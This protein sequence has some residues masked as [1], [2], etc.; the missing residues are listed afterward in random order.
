MQHQV[1]AT[2]AAAA[3][4]ATTTCKREHVKIEVYHALQ[5][6]TFCKYPQLLLRIITASRQL[7][8]HIY[9]GCTTLFV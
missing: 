7:S 9:M 4:E 1:A 5:H 6:S 3:A 2:A 8:R